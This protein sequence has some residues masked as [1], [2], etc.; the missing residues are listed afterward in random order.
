MRQLLLLFLLWT[1]L[2]AEY[3]GTV[4]DS[5]QKAVANAVLSNGYHVV[6]T[7]KDGKF[8]LP[9]WEKARFVTL[10]PSSTQNCTQR[11]IEIK[12]DKKN[13]DFKVTLKQ[14]KTDVN[15]VQVSDTEVFKDGDKNKR[16]WIENLQGYIKNHTPDFL[17]HTGDIC[18]VKGMDFHAQEFTQNTLGV[19][20]YY[21]VGNHDLVRGKYGEEYFEKLFGPSWY[22]FENAGTLFVVTPMMGGDARPSYNRKNIGEWIENLL[23]VYPKAQA[24]VFFNHTKYSFGRDFVYN[25]DRDKKIDLKAYNLK[26][27]VYGHLHSNRFAKHTHADGKT[28]SHIKSYGTGTPFV[29]GI[30]H[31]PSSYRVLHVDKKGDIKSKLRWTYLDKKITLASPVSSIAN[32][33]N[34]E[35]T[36]LVN[37]YD[38]AAEINSIRVKITRNNERGSVIAKRSLKKLSDW[39]WETKFKASSNKKYFLQ[40]EARLKGGKI[41]TTSRSFTTK[42]LKDKAVVGENIN[43]AGNPEHQAISK[44]KH[45]LP[46]Q[47]EWMVNAGSNIFMG[48][49]VIINGKLYTASIDDAE[50]EKCFIICY[51]A[52]TGEELWRYKTKSSIKNQMVAAQGNII[53]TDMFG[54]TYALNLETGKESWK[55]DLY[56]E[57]VV[58][59]AVTD[60]KI[61][62]TGHTR[63]L[64]AIDAKTGKRLWRNK[65]GGGDGTPTT[66]TLTDNAVICSAQW[67]A[68]FA[69]DK[70]TGKLLWKRNDSGLRFRNGTSTFSKGALWLT[71]RADRSA[72]KGVLHK[73]DAKTG[74]TL[75]QF[76]T[77]MLHESASTPIITDKEIILA[78]SHP[79][80]ASYDHE[81][82]QKWQF[83]VDSALFYTI[84]YYNGGEQSI[85]TTPILI[86]G[87]IIFGAMDGK[88]YAI[89]QST[90]KKLWE[91]DLGSPI[92]NT[93]AVT[94]NR[95]YVA[96]FAGNIYCFRASK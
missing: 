28:H 82:K 20:V 83:Q 31:S 21:C 76:E 36:I 69:L 39:A 47:L 32:I 58:N 65:V 75:Q 25:I 73:L 68:L 55:H 30:D 91:A 6:R 94:Q 5:K 67:N 60:G 4:L 44:E 86:N 45:Q 42:S 22:A 61:V 11:F 70:S 37:S 52:K 81:G 13:Y 57:V 78:S 50:S 3:S 33:N 59:G 38:S 46:Y 56:T 79:G 77:G 51:D 80:L 10:Y 48:S 1:S 14:A 18:Y 15:F 90:G 85:E 84:P 26:A 34:S 2:H 16:D 54:V 63:G 17:I 88:L 53:G 35:V 66:M 92:L 9:T 8:S 41:I 12:A 87:H 71:D 62:Y 72:K 19:P 24:K 40:V 29:G 96:D 23:K 89:E 95:I 7:D 49:P 27:W 64:V 74:K 43:L 93:V